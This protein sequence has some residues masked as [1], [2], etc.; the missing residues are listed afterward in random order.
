M[1]RV[2]TLSTLFPDSSRPRF[3]PFVEAQT[4]A[5]AARDDVALRVVA[6]LGVPPLIGAFLPRY[7]P[8][9]ALPPQEDW[10]GIPVHR[11]RFPHLPGPA[12][13]SDARALAHAILPVLEAIRRDFPFDV[14]DAQFFW[15]DGPAA[16]ALGKEL[17]VPVSIK[18]RGSDIN[19]WGGRPG[20]GAQ[21]VAAA[22]R[23]DGMLAVSAA[24][25]AEMVAR[26]M[27]AERI[28][29][30]YTGLDHQRFGVR[31]RAAAKAALGVSGPLIVSIANLVARKG[32]Q[33]VIA[34]MPS[35]PKT[36]LVII[37]RGEHEAALAR[38]IETL[39][40]GHRVAL[41]GAQPHTVIADWLAAADAMVLM[42][43]SEGLAN[44]W[45]EALASGTPLVIS[46]A[47]GAREVV[48]RPETGRIVT[49]DPA[50]VA[51]AVT[52]LL[53]ADYPRST[54]AQGTA[55]FSWG[56]NAQELARHLRSL[57]ETHR[58]RTD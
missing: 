38:Q 42:S 27:P 29:V 18:A 4:L 22:H 30:H 31:D 35:L 46:D 25:K 39:D 47:G 13:R 36:R 37:G 8:L 21:L 2:L 15:P 28:T 56:R 48:D 7:R 49:R 44:S 1:L 40:L 24:L 52:E 6:P 26:G 34:A 9:A 10:K 12:A 14:I 54:V 45:I 19:F 51:A 57:V 43:E 50:A 55:R 16:I 17:G 5:L 41:L 33:T 53:A 3:A 23:A 20:I 11:P 58:D 32:H